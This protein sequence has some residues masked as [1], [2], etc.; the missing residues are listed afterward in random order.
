M[1]FGGQVTIPGE[2]S[3]AWDLVESLAREK[4]NRKT[5]SDIV[6]RTPTQEAL[7]LI[8]IN[9]LTYNKRALQRKRKREEI[10]ALKRL[11]RQ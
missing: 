9:S 7:K 6:P 8:G 2:V 4:K 10:N 11:M 5:S 1:K 3:H